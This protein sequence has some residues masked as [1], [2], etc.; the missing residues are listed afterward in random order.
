VSELIMN[1]RVLTKVWIYPGGKGPLLQN[2]K[3][4]PEAGNRQQSLK[5]ASLLR[6]GN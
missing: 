5:W 6:S 2:A 3:S 4:K 1:R